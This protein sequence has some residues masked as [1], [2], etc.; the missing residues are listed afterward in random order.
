MEGWMS[1]HRKLLSSDLWLSEPFTRG[2]AWADMIGLANHK[3]GFIRVRGINVTIKRGQVGWSEVRLAGRWKWSR[4]K[5]RR[6]LK[7]LETRQQIE[8]QK[9]NVTLLLSI[10]NYDT[11]QE[12]DNKKDSRRTAER[13]Q[14]DTN[15]NVNNENK[16]ISIIFE[17]FRQAY[18]G[19]KRGLKTELEYF[20]KN[21][22][23]ETVHLLSPALEKEKNHKSKSKS[24][25]LFVP[26]W[27]NLKTWISQKCWEQEFTETEQPRTPQLKTEIKVNPAW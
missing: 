12:N 8:Q 26:E 10:V 11:Y 18:P 9:N 7:E 2:Q 27:K 19:T 24:L 1:I 4:S 14:K 20:I 3:D 23:P 16:K 6:F 21:N 17:A 13:Q 22:D 25:G 5:I 15:N